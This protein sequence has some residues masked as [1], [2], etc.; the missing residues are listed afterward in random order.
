MLDNTPLVT[1]PGEISQPQKLPAGIVGLVA[2]QELEICD[3]QLQNLPAETGA[4]QN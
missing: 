1:L 4:L 3:A 2:L